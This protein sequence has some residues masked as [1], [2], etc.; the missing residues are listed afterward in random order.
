MEVPIEVG[1]HEDCSSGYEE[2]ISHNSEGFGEIR[3]S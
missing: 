3:K 1:L 2:G